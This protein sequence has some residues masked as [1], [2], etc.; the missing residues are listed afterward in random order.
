MR[1]I[2]GWIMTNLMNYMI[3]KLNNQIMVQYK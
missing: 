2:I 1:M 3:T